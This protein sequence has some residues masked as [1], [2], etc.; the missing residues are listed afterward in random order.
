L[1]RHR[2]ACDPDELLDLTLP[3][4]VIANQLSSA[5]RAGGGKLDIRS[6]RGPR[7]HR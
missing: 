4:D 5:P 1:A 2:S 3:D 7:V 6:A